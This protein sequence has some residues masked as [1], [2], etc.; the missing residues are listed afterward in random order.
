MRN[1]S[2]ILRETKRRLVKANDRNRRNLQQF[3]HVQN[4]MRSVGKKAKKNVGKVNEITSDIQGKWRQ[5]L[6]D[7]EVALLHSVFDRYERKQSNTP[8]GAPRDVSHS[9]F[10]EF[11]MMLPKR[12]SKR[13]ERMGIFSQFAMDK[14][15]I[16]R[17]DFINT[18]ETFAEMETD[19]KDV[20][21]FITPTIGSSP[22]VSSFTFTV[23]ESNSLWFPANSPSK[24]DSEYSDL[25]K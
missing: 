5:E 8:V 11:Q 23:R 17:G 7:N 4:R 15:H 22:D 19:N 18:F 12:Y 2:G 3:Q 16:E 1:A 13:F 9:G 20:E 6:L 10:K 24:Q 25:K 21:F 14:E